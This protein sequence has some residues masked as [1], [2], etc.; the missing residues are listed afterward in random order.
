MIERG[1]TRNS[2]P[3]NNGLGARFHGVSPPLRNEKSV[4]IFIYLIH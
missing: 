3:D 2:A 4:T 1:A